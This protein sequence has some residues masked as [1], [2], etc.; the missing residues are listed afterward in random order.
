MFSG[1][2]FNWKGLINNH[3]DWRRILDHFKYKWSR[4]PREGSL[5]FFGDTYKDLIETR[6]ETWTSCRE[7]FYRETFRDFKGDFC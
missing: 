7:D 6:L 5:N 3:K 1:T 2:C 4:R